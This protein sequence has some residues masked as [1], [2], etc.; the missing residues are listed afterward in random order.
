[1]QDDI[2]SLQNVREQN[3]PVPKAVRCMETF[4]SFMYLNE[5]KIINHLIIKIPLKPALQF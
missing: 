4:T 5:C 3:K 1:M 2:F